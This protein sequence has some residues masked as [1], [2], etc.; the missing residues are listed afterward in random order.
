MD[1]ISWDLNPNLQPARASPHRS[2]LCYRV[3]PETFAQTRPPESMTFPRPFL[4]EN[5]EEF[6]L[7]QNAQNIEN[8][9]SSGGQEKMS[10][11]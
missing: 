7:P 8:L 6:C 9:Q 11:S 4:M 1:D 2:L 3:T 10:L 5:V